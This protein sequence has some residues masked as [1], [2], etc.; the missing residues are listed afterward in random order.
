V[1]ALGDAAGAPVPVRGSAGIG[2]A[3]AVLPGSLSP[4]RVEE[5]LDSLRNVLMARGGRAV[6]VSAPWEIARHVDMATRQ[7]MF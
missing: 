6:I 3:F 1:Y 5:I 4:E 7:E 2:S